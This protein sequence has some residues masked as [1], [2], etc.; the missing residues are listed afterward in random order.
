MKK[1]GHPDYHLITVTLTNGTS[2]QTRSTYAEEGA[3]LVLDVD[4]PRRGLGLAAQ[5]HAQHAVVAQRAEHAAASVRLQAR[6]QADV[7]AVV[8]QF[9]RA[10]LADDVDAVV[11]G[12][13]FA[14]VHDTVVGDEL[15]LDRF[16]GP[17]DA[18]V[19]DCSVGGKVGT[20]EVVR[21]DAGTT[22]LGLVL[23]NIDTLDSAADTT[24]ET[25]ELEGVLFAGVTDYINVRNNKTWNMIDPVWGVT[26]YTDLVWVG[27]TSNTVNDRRSIKA[28]VAEADGTALVNALVNIYENTQLADLVLELLT[29][30]N[31]YAE[32]SFIY[33][34]H[35][36][37]S[38]TT[39][40]GGHALQAGKWLYLPFVAAQLSTEAFQ[41][42]IVL[43]PDPNVF[44]HT[45]ALAGLKQ[46]I[47]VHG[48]GHLRVLQP[49]GRLSRL[50]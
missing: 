22:V 29:D 13:A 48:D 45:N 28:T 39:T 37:N 3:K 8:H 18:T 32:D 31:G 43:S 5:A 44:G 49:G 19:V 41:G 40:Y 42:T 50:K 12:P 2:F 11:V 4:P 9:A 6:V 20:T 17:Y 15:R 24:T 25:I 1:E 26:D 21:V 34:A 7:A 36:T 47:S 33:K 38:A 16:D 30:T 23:A 14:N 27:S 10:G 35:V 46:G